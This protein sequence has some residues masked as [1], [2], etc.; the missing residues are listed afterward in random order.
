[1]R[2]SPIGRSGKSVIAKLI[3]HLWYG[4]CAGMALALVQLTAPR[5][6]PQILIFTSSLGA[7]MKSLQ[8]GFTLI[9]L[10]IVIAIIGILAAIAIPAYQNYTIRAQI[11][12][13]LSL[14]DNYKTA[15]AE[16]YQN[17]GAFPQ[18]TSLTGS[19]TTIPMP[20]ASQGKYVSAVTIDTKGNIEITYAGPQAS[21]KLANGNVLYLNVGTD[22]N[23]DVAWVCGLQ[24]TTPPAGV[25]LNGAATTTIAPQYLPASCHL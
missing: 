24:S 18:G 1:M 25:T 12:E 11:T 6:A 4:S 20:G 10:M 23:G 17:L 14:A 8:K 7:S 19:S 3:M 9:E 22:T 2:I 15:V 13:G 16:F 21:A 5:I